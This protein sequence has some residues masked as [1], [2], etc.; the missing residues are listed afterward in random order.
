MKAR[1]AWDPGRLAWRDI[2]R[3]VDAIHRTRLGSVVTVTVDVETFDAIARWAKCEG[4]WSLVATGRGELPGFE[5]RA[6]WSG[7]LDE[8]SVKQ[9]DG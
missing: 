3:N 5:L 1:G 4:A 2:C 6:D 9:T 7:A 8:Q